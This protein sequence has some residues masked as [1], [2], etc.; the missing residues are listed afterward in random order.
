MMRR[1][2]LK[3]VLIIL[4][5]FGLPLLIIG[6]LVSTVDRKQL[7]E[8]QQRTIN[9]PLIAAAFV[10]HFVAVSLCFHRWYLL[11]RALDIP[12]RIRDAFRLGFL[13]YLLNFVSVGIV[14]GDLFKAIFIAREQPGRRTL[15][16]ASIMAD[17]IIGLYALLLVTSVALLVAP[18]PPDVGSDVIAVRTTTYIVTIVG[19]IGLLLV[20]SPGFTSGPIA[21]WAIALPRVGPLFE[22]M[23]F[24]VR[25]YRR[26]PLVL[27]ITTFESFGVHVFSAISVH[28]IA[29]ALYPEAPT[30]GE[31]L[32][33]VPLSNLAGALPLTPMGLGTMEYAMRTLYEVIPAN[34]TKFGIIVALAFRLVTI[35]I[36]AVGIV[37]Y[38]FSRREMKSMLRSGVA[39]EPDEYRAPTN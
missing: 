27:T 8:L 33:I 16:V 10:I 18:F 12:F 28:L 15:A 39:R 14:G 11:V 24:A 31:H 38:W 23:I 34:P 25:C 30:L 36:A 1:E 2:A 13:G 29:K 9:W 20:I 6:W 7:A 4:L 21:E 37:V 35:A 19:G 26:Q 5:K 22:R 32:I 17:R 3:K